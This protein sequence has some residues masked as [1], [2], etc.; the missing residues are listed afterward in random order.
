MY[1]TSVFAVPK[2]CGREWIDSQLEDGAIERETMKI[3]KR[4]RETGEINCLQGDRRFRGDNRY[5]KSHG[6]SFL[7]GG[8]DSSNS[9]EALT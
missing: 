6:G 3:H 8:L 9:M 5:T 7:W 2:E 4:W 1:V